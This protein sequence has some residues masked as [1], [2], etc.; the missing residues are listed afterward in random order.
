MAAP[1]RPDSASVKFSF[2]NIGTIQEADLQ[3]GDLTIIAGRNNTGKTYLVYTLYG[4]LKLW[5]SGLGAEYLSG[6][7]NG[8]HMRELYVVEA[9]I[10]AIQ[11]GRSEVTIDHDTFTNECVLLMN[12]LAREFS[13][14]YLPDVFN[15]REEYFERSQVEIAIK[16]R[17]SPCTYSPKSISPNRSQDFYAKYD[18]QSMHITAKV[19]KASQFPE[20]LLQ[21]IDHY[22][23]FLFPELNIV[24]FLI[25]AERLGTTLFYRELDFT[26]HQLVD[27]LQRLGDDKDKDKLS[28]YVIIDRTTSRY[29]MP[30][31][32][33]ID[34]TRAIADIRKQKSGMYTEKLYD[35]IRDM[36]QGYYRSDGDEIMFISTARGERRFEIPLHIASS[37]AR[38]LAG[39]YF[40]LRH[41]AQNDHLLIIDEPESHLDTHNQIMMARLLAR[42]V[43][44]G[45]KVLVT[46]HSDYIIKEINNLV[47]FSGDFA[48]KDDAV[49]RHKYGE[50]DFISPESIKAYVAEGGGLTEC[51]VDKFGMAM[52]MF[53]D[54]IDDINRVSN[55][56]AS[57]LYQS[58]ETVD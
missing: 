26:K 46:T 31:K 12:F 30:I 20:S 32:D 58:E 35:D 14:A 55:D 43:K 52:P 4:F 34:Y 50:D 54:T 27:L 21:S 38:E 17:S 49:R 7:H 10:D 15:S 48:G 39:L 25:P 2:K 3:L 33:N 23:R 29:A 51:T 40:Y 1:D 11:D 9:M 57:R 22:S 37:S 13:T 56:L 24:P 42:L 19:D 45:I 18:G 36:M 47:M 6:F 5:R 41:V 44:R 28:P 8:D 53:D 16:A